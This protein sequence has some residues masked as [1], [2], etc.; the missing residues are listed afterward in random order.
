MEGAEMRAAQRVPRGRHHR[1]LRPL[2]LALLAALTLLASAIAY[3]SPA[4]AQTGCV[5]AACEADLAIDISDSTDPVQPGAPF[6]TYIAITNTGPERAERVTVIGFVE[7]SALSVGSLDCSIDMGLLYC[8]VGPLDAGE[9]VT[10]V[11]ETTLDADGVALAGAGVTHDG[12]DTDPEDDF[13]LEDTTIGAGLPTLPEEE[14]PGPLVLTPS[15]DSFVKQSSKGANFGSLTTLEVDG[16]PLKVVLMSFDLSALGGNVP[17][18]AT[19]RLYNVD[20][21]PDGGA[22]YAS[23]GQAWDESTVTYSSR[24]RWGSAPVASIGPVTAGAW[25]EVDVLPLVSGSE[26]TFFLVSSSA[27]GADYSSREGAHPPELVITF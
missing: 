17:T 27:N 25:Y 3:H 22:V 8:D 18:S 10:A 15:H 6:Q 19:L 1:D 21:S 9:S 24:P 7:P 12:I 20:P 14:A 11:I 4:Q 26:A 13:D 5:P 16:D 23:D 2:S